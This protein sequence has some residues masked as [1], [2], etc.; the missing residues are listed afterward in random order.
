MQSFT[1]SDV[2]YFS[3]C[4]WQYY[5][6]EWLYVVYLCLLELPDAASYYHQTISATYLG[7]LNSYSPEED[8]HHFADDIFKYIFMNEK[9]CICFIQIS[10]VCSE[11]S[12]WQ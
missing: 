12:N 7:L 3:I 11:W 9:L 5:F 1:A 2:E 6:G 8:G 10:Q 4:R